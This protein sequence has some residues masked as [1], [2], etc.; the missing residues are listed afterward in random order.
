MERL[1]T[2]SAELFRPYRETRGTSH[3]PHPPEQSVSQNELVIQRGKHVQDDESDKNKRKIEVR[4]EGRINR[5]ARR[6]RVGRPLKH[7]SVE[8]S[9]NGRRKAG[10]TINKTRI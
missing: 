5:K 8:S 10:P 7:A 9:Q 2:E 1:S 6:E 4:H 3:E